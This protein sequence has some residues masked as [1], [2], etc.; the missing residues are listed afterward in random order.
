VLDGGAAGMTGSGAVGIWR[1]EVEEVI[2]EQTRG[3]E[4]GYSPMIP[5]LPMFPISSE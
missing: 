3:G 4:A 2:S 5:I 1:K